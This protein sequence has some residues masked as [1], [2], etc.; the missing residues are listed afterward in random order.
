MRIP[1]KRIYEQLRSTSTVLTITLTLIHG[2]LRKNLRNG[3]ALSHEV[4]GHVIGRGIARV[5][6]TTSFFL[7][8]DLS[9]Q[10]VEMVL[11]TGDEMFGDTG[12][13]EERR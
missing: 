4:G 7:G 8:T 11:V 1:I 12:A 13:G 9:L 5:Q 6:G 3:V 2:G 10:R